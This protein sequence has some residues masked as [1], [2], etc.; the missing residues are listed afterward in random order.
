[1]TVRVDELQTPINAKHRCF[2]EGFCHLT[3]DS[4]DEL[5][6]FAKQLR[7]KR[8]WFQPHRL[9]PHYDLTLRKR[10]QALRL[11]AEFMPARHQMAAK[12]IALDIIKQAKAEGKC[13]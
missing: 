11:G 5:H 1:M 13:R 7:L 9:M 12:L 3:A 6:A 10:A 4:L 8:A 2:R